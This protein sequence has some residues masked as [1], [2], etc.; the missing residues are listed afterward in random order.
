MKRIIMILVLA[1]SLI[2]LT[3]VANAAVYVRGHY[4]SSGTYVAPHYRSNPDGIRSNNWS[5]CGNTNPYTGKV[6]YGD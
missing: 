1:I 4:R 3:T 5:C 6:G 2:G